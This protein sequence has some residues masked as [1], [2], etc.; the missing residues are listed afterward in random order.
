MIYEQ[1]E[2]TGIGISRY[3][4]ILCSSLINKTSDEF[5]S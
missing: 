5:V 2:Q 1:A 4:E 3:D